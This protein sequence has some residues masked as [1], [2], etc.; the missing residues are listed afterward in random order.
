MQNS[1]EQEDG[2]MVNVSTHITVH[3]DLGDFDY[4]VEGYCSVCE[5]KKP[6][7]YWTDKLDIRSFALCQS[8]AETIVVIHQ[9]RG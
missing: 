9:K 8:C 6:V 7:V 1:R 4:F 5:K 3:N 2:K